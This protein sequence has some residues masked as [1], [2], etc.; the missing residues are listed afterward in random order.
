[1]KKKEKPCPKCGEHCYAV[2]LNS[3][4]KKVMRE[5]EFCPKC[6]AHLSAS[7]I[8]LNACHLS[9]ESQEKFNRLFAAVTKSNV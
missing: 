9:A 1:M 4:G 5:D 2:L 8:C 7:G 3:R 6:N